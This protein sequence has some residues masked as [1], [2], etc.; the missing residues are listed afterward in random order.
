MYTVSFQALLAFALLALVSGA[1]ACLVSYVKLFA[2]PRPSL[3]RYFGIALIV[4]IVS[5]L[6]GSFTGIAVLCSPTAGNLCGI[7]GA[8][9][10]GPLLCGVSLWLYGPV[11][12][13]RAGRVA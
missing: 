7:W 2:P 9:V 5:Y 4:A 12:R 6:V 3:V 1:V 8:L 13:R 11:Y 10:S